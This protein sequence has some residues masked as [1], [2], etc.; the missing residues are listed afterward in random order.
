MTQIVERWL[1]VEPLLLAAWTSHQLI[2]NLRLRTLRIQQGQIEYNPRFIDQLTDR[3]LESTLKFEALRIL[4][5][6][7]YSRRQSH[8]A[9]SYAASNVTI[10]EYMQTDLPFPP[11]CLRIRHMTN[12]TLSSTTANCWSNSITR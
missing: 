4:L 9:I 5:K 12:N 2:A 11:I 1:L 8:T 3:D 6:H 10:Q 7:P